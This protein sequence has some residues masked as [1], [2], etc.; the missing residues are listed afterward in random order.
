M[1][2]L[3]NTPPKRESFQSTTTFL[4]KQGKSL[5]R[6]SSP[7]H[8]AEL[9]AFNYNYSTLPTELAKEL[10]NTTTNIRVHYR[11]ALQSLSSVGLQL[12]KTKDILPRGEWVNW[13]KQEFDE[14]GYFSIYTAENYM[15]LAR[16]VQAHGLENLKNLPLSVLYILSREQD[17]EFIEK[18]LEQSQED[19]ISRTRYRQI[20]SEFNN[21][22]IAEESSI[23]TVPPTVKVEESIELCPSV[24]TTVEAKLDLHLTP[25]HL[26]FTPT[27]TNYAQLTEVVIEQ[28]ETITYK[29]VSSLELE[30]TIFDYIFYPITGPNNGS[31][32]SKDIF[33]KLKFLMK[34][35]AVCFVYSSPLDLSSVMEAA[36]H[37]DLN[38]LATFAIK[39]DTTF[40]PDLNLS[41]GWM[42]CTLFY[43]NEYPK[44]EEYFKDYYSDSTSFIYSMLKALP[45]RG[46]TNSLLIQQDNSTVF[47]DEDILFQLSNHYSH[48]VYNY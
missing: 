5:F 46:S 47:G 19:S 37:S 1:S 38:Y 14:P 15:N 39:Q 13:V 7:S 2:N 8:I 41:C 44:F 27:V 6:S 4:A 9:E 33:S 48:F 28:E 43:L 34:D 30:N 18:I 29:T 26:E 23:A 20:K 24:E 17:E 36:K 42:S 12:I 16:L 45:K 21:L 31:G 22:Q 3:L 40:R 25:K 35:C 10:K 32:I 11:N